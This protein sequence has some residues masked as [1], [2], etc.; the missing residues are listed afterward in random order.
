MMGIE[1]TLL[2]GPSRSRLA[3]DVVWLGFTAF[4]FAYA[5]GT[6]HMSRDFILSAVMAAACV[7]FFT[8]PLAGHLSVGGFLAVARGTLKATE[9]HDVE[10]TGACRWFRAFLREWARCRLWMALQPWDMQ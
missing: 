2:I 1:A 6:L 9:E 8:I 5:V 4:V 7:S 10:T 3:G